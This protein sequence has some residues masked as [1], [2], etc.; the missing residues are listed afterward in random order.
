MKSLLNSVRKVLKSQEVRTMEGLLQELHEFNLVYFGG[1]QNIKKL[2]KDWQ[3]GTARNL[4]GCCAMLVSKTEKQAVFLESMP[5]GM[6]FPLHWHEAVEVLRVLKGAVIDDH[7][8]SKVLKPGDEIIYQSSQKHEP[9]N[10]S[11]EQEAFI[12]VIIKF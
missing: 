9:R 3:V 5:P 7:V 8:R 12:E 6:A 1:Y 4:H 2:I 10:Y 11:K